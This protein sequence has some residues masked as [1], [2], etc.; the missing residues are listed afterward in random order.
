L[1]TKT[2][3]KTHAQ[4]NPRPAFE[5]WTAAFKKVYKDEHVRECFA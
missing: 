4:A 1:L 2:H 5:L 3:S